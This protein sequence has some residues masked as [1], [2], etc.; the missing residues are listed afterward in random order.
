MLSPIFAL[1]VLLPTPSQIEA[2][3]SDDWKTREITHQRLD[4]LW[5]SRFLPYHHANPEIQF[6]LQQIH[7]RWD[8]HEEKQLYKTDFFKWFDI[9]CVSGNS[10]IA[11]RESVY[12]RL[13]QDEELRDQ[14]SQKYDVPI[15]YEGG[16]QWIPVFQSLDGFN[17]FLAPLDK[18]LIS[19]NLIGEAFLPNVFSPSL[20]S[21]S[22]S[23]PR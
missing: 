4:S 22:V 21:G 7:G 5:C 17:D 23:R 9:H 16:W 19:G 8:N 3:G 12:N 1:M 6:R 13:I 11:D 18:R 15:N 20:P 10:K 2:L 14:F